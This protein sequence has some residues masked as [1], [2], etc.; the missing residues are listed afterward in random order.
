M[1]EKSA[2]NVALGAGMRSA[3]QERGHTQ[4]SFAALAGI[5][6]RYYGTVERGE[7]SPTINFVAKVADGLGMRMSALFVRAGL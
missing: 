1:A 6:S 2:V 3:R 7:F 4:Q 5:S